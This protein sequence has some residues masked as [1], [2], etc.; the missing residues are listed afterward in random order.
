[1]QLGGRDGSV[2]MDN[3]LYDLYSKC[4]ISYDAAISRA[5][6]PDRFKPNRD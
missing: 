4:L 2:L 3:C 1:M 5:R 6:D